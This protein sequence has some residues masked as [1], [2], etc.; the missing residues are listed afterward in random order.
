MSAFT[1]REIKYHKKE[2]RKNGATIE[3]TSERGLQFKNEHYLND[4]TILTMKAKGLFKFKGVCHVSMKK[5][6]HFAEVHLCGK[7]SKV[8]SGHCSC[9][10]GNSYFYS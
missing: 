6:K 7:F 2:S 8:I 3:K 5:E 9:S 10:A 1:A 4:D